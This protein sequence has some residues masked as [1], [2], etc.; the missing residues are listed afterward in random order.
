MVMGRMKEYCRGGAGRERIAIKLLNRTRGKLIVRTM[1]RYHVLKPSTLYILGNG[2]DIHHGMNCKYADFK[3][4]LQKNSPEVYR[5]MSR[6]YGNHLDS[7]K[8]WQDFENNLAYF[9]VEGYPKRITQTEYHKYKHEM[10]ELY[11]QEAADAAIDN[12]E[13]EFPRDISNQFHRVGY[14]ARFE[15]QQLKEAL[16]AAFNEWVENIALPS[17]QKC[18]RDIDR[19]AL[20]MTFNYTRT[21][22]D[23]YGIEEE[24]V[25]HMHGVVG[26]HEEFVVGHGLTT[27]QIMDMDLDDNVALRDPDKDQGE[28]NA[29]LAIFEV[30]GDEMKKPVQEI[31]QEK[32]DFFNALRGIEKVIVLG[33]SY[34]PIDRPYLDRVFEVVGRDIK[35]VLGGHSEDDKKNAESFQ[36]SMGLRNAEFCW[37]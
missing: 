6:L 3:S 26:G 34:S 37:F 21:L 23:V 25:Q 28:D 5:I 33:F 16:F 7:A 9:D 24:N 15:M 1:D 35:V 22:E 30:L 20:F 13:I 8:W 10:E 31:I 2:F 17:E 36:T 29:R 11:G 4:W 12:Y 19:N 32:Q 18:M 27:E 14:W